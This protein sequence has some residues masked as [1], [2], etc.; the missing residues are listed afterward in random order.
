[1]LH[2][3]KPDWRWGSILDIAHTPTHMLTVPKLRDE[4]QI[5]YRWWRWRPTRKPISN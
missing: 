3:R 1:L 5:K 4:R 2:W